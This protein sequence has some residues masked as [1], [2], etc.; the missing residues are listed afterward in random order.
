MVCLSVELYIVL[1]LTDPEDADFARFHNLEVRVSCTFRNIHLFHSSSLKYRIN[2][3]L[4]DKG[5]GFGVW[6]HLMGTFWFHELLPRAHLQGS[7][8]EQDA[9]TKW[10]HCH[11][12][13]YNVT[14][15]D[16]QRTSPIVLNWVLGIY[17]LPLSLQSRKEAIFEVELEMVLNF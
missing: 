11:R 6:G 15:F 2:I 10:G 9:M 17:F 5:V 8:C 14:H 3:S 13:H 4:E 16:K 1:R 7:I 12:E